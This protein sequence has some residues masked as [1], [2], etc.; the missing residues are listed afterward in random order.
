MTS[1]P[2]SH[3][4]ATTDAAQTRNGPRILVIRNDKIGDFMLAWPA[5]AL[6][7]RSLPQAHI[8]VLVPGYTRGLA[9]LCP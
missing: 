5:L 2:S 4:F 9:L 3:S 8:S 6:L 7:R 1:Q